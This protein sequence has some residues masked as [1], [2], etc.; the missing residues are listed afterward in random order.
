MSLKLALALWF[1]AQPAG[2][3]TPPADRGEHFQ[4]PPFVQTSDGAGQVSSRGYVFSFQGGGRVSARFTP[5]ATHC[6]SMIAHFTLD[7]GADRAS[8]PLAAA[9]TSSWL[10]LG[11][12][13]AG[14]HEVKVNAEGVTGG[15][16]AG[17]LASW[18]GTLEVR[19]QPGSPPGMPDPGDWF[20]EIYYAGGLRPHAHDCI[21]TAAGAVYTFEASTPVPRADDAKH[22]HHYDAGYLAL[23][24]GSDFVTAPD[25]EAGE[26][27]ALS[28]FGGALRRAASGRHTRQ[29]ES[30][31][32]GEATVTGWFRTGVNDYQAA[33]LGGFGDWRVTNS[34]PGAAEA[35][36]SLRMI[37][38]PDCRF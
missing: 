6:S 4:M 32:A 7:G 14:P 33:V 11:T 27:Q 1:M 22:G 8:Y 9:Q 18:G 31:D 23:R 10:D 12:A 28:G 30:M 37:Q 21:I 13:P 29:N 15:C 26:R 5:L 17:R 36:R 25:L 2:P 35:L 20:V 38:R 19:L 34:S 3:P 24:L 16:N